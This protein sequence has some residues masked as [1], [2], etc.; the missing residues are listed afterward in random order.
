MEKGLSRDSGNLLLLASGFALVSLVLMVPCSLHAASNVQMITSSGQTLLSIFEDLS[1]SRFARYSVPTRGGPRKMSSLLDERALDGHLG[2]RYLLACA[3]C[4]PG[5]CFGS[6][7]RATPCS[8]CCTDPVGCP[9]LNNYTTDSKNYDQDDQVKDQP[10][11]ADC[12]NDF[13]NCPD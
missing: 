9:A 13:T 7:E 6:F 8:G 2:A 11:G 4:N 3:T 10:C 5:S 1:P 12:C